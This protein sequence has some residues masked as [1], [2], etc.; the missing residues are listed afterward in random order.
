M[1]PAARRVV[2]EDP[3]EKLVRR[4]MT[5]LELAER[6]GDVAGSTGPASTTGIGAFRPMAWT[7]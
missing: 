6:L 4:R 1:S 5:V 7:D 3:T 2:V